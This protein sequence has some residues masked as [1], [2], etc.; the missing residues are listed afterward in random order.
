M[1]N[2]GALRCGFVRRK[3]IKWESDTAG[4]AARLRRGG[5][6]CRRWV[7]PT[8]VLVSLTLVVVLSHLQ[9]ASHDNAGVTFARQT[10]SRQFPA[11][12]LH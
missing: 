1:L 9:N 12:E 4:R 10:N 8:Y 11:N 3:E 7:A 2:S 5:V 6:S